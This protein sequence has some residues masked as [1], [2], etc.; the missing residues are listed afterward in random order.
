M[1]SAEYNHILVRMGMRYALIAVI[2]V[3][4]TCGSVSAYE[5]HVT[6][7]RAGVDAQRAHDEAA[8]AMFE[9]MSKAKP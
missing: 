8:R 6:A 9:S 2:V 7:Q 3:S 4:A 5:A 1:T